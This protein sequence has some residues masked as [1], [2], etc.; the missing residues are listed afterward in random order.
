MDL[1]LNSAAIHDVSYDSAFTA[2]ESSASKPWLVRPVK[3]SDCKVTD[4]GSHVQ[5]VL[6]RID[7]K[8]EKHIVALN[9]EKGEITFVEGGHDVERVTVV[10]EEPILVRDLPEKRS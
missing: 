2:S 1:C 7:G 3:G 5:R 10:F 9:E 4:C 8:V 6:T